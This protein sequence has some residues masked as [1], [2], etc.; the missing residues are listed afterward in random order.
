M[1]VLVIVAHPDDEVLG[2]GAT[3]KKLTNDGHDVKVVILATGI[4]SRRSSD[5]TN[6][7]D[8]EINEKIKNITKKQLKELQKDAKNAASIMGVTKLEMMDFPDNEMDKI[9]NLEITKKIEKIIEEFRPVIVFTHS[10]YDLN[11]DH[12]IIYNATIT[13][14]RPTKKFIV[15]KK[16]TLQ[17]L[18][19]VCLHVFIFRPVKKISPNFQ[20]CKD[21][22]T[23]KF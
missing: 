19:K 9:T 12:K 6:S 18:I 7:T 3:I 23:F 8:Y 10:E 1:K 15:K 4:T 5:Y 21:R 11:I 22:N 2:M 20:Y 17:N 16:R 14:T 13:A